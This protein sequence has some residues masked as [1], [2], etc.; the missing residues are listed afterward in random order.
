MDYAFPIQGLGRVP[1]DA[2]GSASDRAFAWT[3][4]APSKP[5]G[6]GLS[7]MPPGGVMLFSSATP[8]SCPAG[9]SWVSAYPP[10][11][12]SPNVPQ[13]TGALVKWMRS[14]AVLYPSKAASDG[15]FY[16]HMGTKTGLPLMYTPGF[17]NVSVCANESSI[18][19]HQAG[20]SAPIV[21][22]GAPPIA[23]LNNPAAMA[24]IL[25][26]HGVGPAPAGQV[27]PTSYTWLWVLLGLGAVGVAG[28]YLID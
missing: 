12:S 17:G 25:A 1:S 13:L 3:P 8:I 15:N 24:A 5:T 28:Y 9:Y 2:P 16:F 6:V 22:S 20:G 21:V 4:P 18:A 10:S 26:T 19:A 7:A 11:P 27:Q 23:V 14:W